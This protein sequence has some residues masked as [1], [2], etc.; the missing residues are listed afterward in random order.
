M[1]M[2]MTALLGTLLS[3][4]VIAGTSAQKDFSEYDLPGYFSCSTPRNWTID[5]D[6]A[7][8]ESD[9]V[10]AVE[11]TSKTPGMPLPHIIHVAYYSKENGEF[12][13]YSDYVSK[14]SKNLFKIRDNKYWP[15]RKASLSGREA[16]TFERETFVYLPPEKP[17]AKKYYLKEK[18]IV[19]DA[20]EGFFVLKYTAPKAQYKTHLKTFQKVADSLKSPKFK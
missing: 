1:K 14:N 18:F 12:S 6:S 15:V 7:P 10:Y 20:K 11:L 13:G 4:S 17:S 8:A 3:V 5:Y 9:A 19:L 2:T 16:K